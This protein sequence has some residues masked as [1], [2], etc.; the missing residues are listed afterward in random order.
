M[1][2]FEERVSTLLGLIVLDNPPCLESLPTEHIHESAAVYSIIGRVI[3]G[4]I[5]TALRIYNFN[6]DGVQGVICNHLLFITK[7]G[8]EK[9]KQKLKINRFFR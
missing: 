7:H 8:Y 9:Y 2:S 5:E 6:G 3:S 1:S 4:D